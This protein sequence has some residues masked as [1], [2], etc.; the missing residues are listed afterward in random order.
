MSA[1]L[2]TYDEVPTPPTLVPHGSKPATFQVQKRPRETDIVAAS[3]LEAQPQVPQFKRMN[4]REWKAKYPDLLEPPE[5]LP[6][7]LACDVLGRVVAYMVLKRQ[8]VYYAQ[9]LQRYWDA[10][11][12]R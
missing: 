7:D 12:E 3:E 8:S 5:G 6:I 9:Q 1:R 11:K 4:A 2:P 10:Q